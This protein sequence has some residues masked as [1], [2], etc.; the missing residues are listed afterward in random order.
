MC[1]AR[2]MVSEYSF[3]RVRSRSIAPIRRRLTSINS[4]GVLPTRSPSE[5]PAACTWSAPAAMAASEFATASPRSLW[6]C[7]ST[8]N[9]SPLG[10]TISSIAK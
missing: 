6:P 7:Q 2:A 3:K 8:R 5:M 4:I 9:F 1:V 10:L